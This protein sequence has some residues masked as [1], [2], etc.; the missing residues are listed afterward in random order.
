MS[1]T[2]VAPEAVAV[3]EDTSEYDVMLLQC[4]CY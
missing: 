4:E 2:T 1:E 3:V